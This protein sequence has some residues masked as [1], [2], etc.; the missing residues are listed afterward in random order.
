MYA[1]RVNVST[2][3]LTSEISEL[4]CV[5]AKLK[6]EIP[7][8]ESLEQVESQKFTALSIAASISGYGWLKTK[9]KEQRKH[10]Q[11][12]FSENIFYISNIIEFT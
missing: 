11:N 5:I 12:I 9:Q 6:M 10:E 4:L 7:S 3:N 1:T 2:Y 8:T